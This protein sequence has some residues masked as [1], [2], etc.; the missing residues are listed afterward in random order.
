MQPLRTRLVA[1]GV[2]AAVA[3]LLY[4]TTLLPGQ[5]L[6]D[7]ASFQAIVG[8]HLLGPRQGYPLYFA[9]NGALARLLP[10]EAAR[11]ANLG[12]AMAAA[13]AVGLVVLVGAELAGSLAAG[14]VAGLLLAGS[15]T[16]WSQAVIA[17][18]YALHLLLASA[19]L[20]ALLAWK[21][22]PSTARLA[23]FFALCALGFGN[24]LSMVLLLPG[25]ALLLLAAA[26]DGPLSMLRPRVV[27]LAAGM[28]ALFA[29]QYA[30]NIR[31]LVAEHP[32]AAVADLARTFWFD[33][34][35]ADWRANM[36]YG[37][38]TSTIADRF[39]MYWFD[40]RQQFGVP[41]VAAAV[42]GFAALLRRQW[43]LGADAADALVRE[44]GVRL[45]LQRRRRPRVLP[46]IALGGRARGRLRSGLGQCPRCRPDDSGPRRSSPRSPSSP[47][48]RGGSGT[49]TRPWTAAT[50]AS[51]RWRS[52]GWSPAWTRAARCWDA[53]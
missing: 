43:R 44:L 16:F 52:T 27:A 32:N 24:H 23:L 15:Y 45:H 48:R 39:A 41:G 40:V 33:V 31:W 29:L 34:T 19:C 17:E 53:T 3:F 7:T 36:V 51:R 2:L 11:A 5:D 12:S 50:T 26:P 10:V 18:V 46:G 14:L 30:W 20:L 6:G 38:P 49:P 28:A 47:T 13:A 37:I 9:L 25:F 21:A 42:V 35:K 8:D 1:A 4:F 22:R